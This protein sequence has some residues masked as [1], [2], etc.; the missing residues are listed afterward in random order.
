MNPQSMT[1]N[2]I[3]NEAGRVSIRI[4]VDMECILGFYKCILVQNILSNTVTRERPEKYLHTYRGLHEHTIDTCTH[5][6]AFYINMTVTRA[7]TL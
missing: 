1:L 5:I 6:I 2:D 7:H 4:Y 3:S